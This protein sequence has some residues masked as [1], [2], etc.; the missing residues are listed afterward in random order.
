MYKLIAIDIDGTLLKNDKTISKE[1]YLAIEKAKAKGI[2][3][4]LSTG[5]PIQGAEKY[6]IKLNLTSNTNYAVAYSGALVQCLGNKEILFESILT[7][8]N[9]KFLYALSQKLNI[10]LN[11]A[12]ANSLLT[13]TL[14][15]TTQVESF[16]S[17]LPV[18]IVDFNDLSKY[19]IIYRVVYL[20]ETQPFIK[21]IKTL[22]KNTNIKY[23]IL[24]TLNRNDD[25]FYH[26][27]NLPSELYNKFTVFKPS[28]NTLEILNKGI[29]KGTGVEVIAHK[30]GIHSEEVICIGDSENDI[31]MIKYAGLGVAMGNASLDVK[32]AADYVTFT[33]EENGLAHV[34][35]KF[36]LKEEEKAV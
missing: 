15:L 11:A 24:D 19:P 1:N 6:S 5:R 27:N 25:L 8:D 34:I 7:H 10:T 30:L 20:N 36:I 32:K 9:I 17:N 28:S 18:K 16:L 4:V 26:K 12:T 2:N 13:P 21:K 14:N 3:I 22:L 31:D 35:N 33:N 29:N 23:N